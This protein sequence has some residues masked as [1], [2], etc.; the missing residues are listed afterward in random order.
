[1]NV[2]ALRHYVDHFDLAD[3]RL[4]V[5]FRKLCAKLYL[6]AETQQVDRILEQFSR[7]YFEDNPQTVYGSSGS[8]HLSLLNGVSG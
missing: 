7:K 8:F 5:A 1:M 6:K 2:A 3:L 4:D